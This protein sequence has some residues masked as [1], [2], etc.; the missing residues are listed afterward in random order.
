MNDS[1]KSNIDHLNLTHT[2]VGDERRDDYL[3]EIEYKQPIFPLPLEYADIDRAMFDFADKK[4]ALDIEGE[5]FPTFTL[6]SNQRFSEYSQTWKHT[7]K[8]GNLLQNFKTVNRD[9]N[10]AQG[11][12]QGGFFNI[13][14]DRRY[15]LLM[16]TVLEDN[17]TESYEI[18]SMKQP[19]A[20]DLTYRIGIITNKYQNLNLFNEKVQDLFKAKQF[21]IRPNKHYVPLT[22]SS[23]TD[24]TTYAVDNMKFYV[25]T[26]QIEANAYIIRKEDFEVVKK[27]KQVLLHMEGDKHRKPKVSLEEAYEL[28]GDKE[29]KTMNVNIGFKPYQTKC[30]F[31]IDEDFKV[32]KIRLTNARKISVN[33][34]FTPYYV[35]RGFEVKNGDLIRIKILPNRYERE[36]SVYLMGYNPS[37][38][39]PAN[40]CH[41]DASKDVQ[42]HEE[43]EVD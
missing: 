8:E 9:N 30:E 39:I 32:E 13:P 1:P 12:N 38:T 29:Y 16:R 34:N 14:G 17:G 43:V 33:V 19:F 37:E 10:P 24:E 6:Y 35:D 40:N 4:I 41:E 22:L 26:A 21:Y 18:Y 5:E 31:R 11:K 25:Q 42:E 20:V 3:N 15:T 28:R 23:V 2:T 27:P 7:D 36:S